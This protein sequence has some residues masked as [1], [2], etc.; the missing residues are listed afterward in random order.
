VIQVKQTQAIESTSAEASTPWTPPN[1][2]RHDFFRLS[3][4][5]RRFADAL[6]H[7]QFWCFGADIRW[8]DG[9]LLVE[10]GCERHRP[11]ER[12]SGSVTYQFQVAPGIDLVLW[13]FGCCWTVES[14]GRVYLSRFSIVPHEL[15]PDAELSAISLPAHLPPPKCA[16]SRDDIDRLAKLTAGL[17]RWFAWYEAWV[18][19]TMGLEGREAALAPWGKKIVCPATEMMTRWSE[20]ANR[21]GERGRTPFLELATREPDSHLVVSATSSPIEIR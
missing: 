21:L 14:I 4:Q 2:Q 19:A 9:N 6:V 11:P 7:Q 17:L 15:D 16:E 8:P 1:R 12:D 5:E 13:G 10:L 20:L 3:G 18:I